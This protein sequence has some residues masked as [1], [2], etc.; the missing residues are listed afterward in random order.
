M[1]D[2]KKTDPLTALFVGLLAAIFGL[3]LL[4]ELLKT[5]MAAAPV[6]IMLGIIGG[7]VWYVVRQRRSHEEY[8]RN[9]R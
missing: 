3:A 8:R 5:L 7:L 4:A 9:H 1:A 6:A 2:S